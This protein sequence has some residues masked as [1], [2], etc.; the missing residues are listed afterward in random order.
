[1]KNKQLRNRIV[2]LIRELKAI[3]LP[4]YELRR[5]ITGRKHSISGI[6]YS[7]YAE[8]H[9]QMLEWSTENNIPLDEIQ[10]SFE[11]ETDWE[12]WSEPILCVSSTALETDDEY[13]PRLLQLKVDKI[14]SKSITD[15]EWAQIFLSINSTLYMARNIAMSQLKVIECLDDLSKIHNAMYNDHNGQANEYD[16]VLKQVSIYKAMKS[17]YL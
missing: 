9:E 17:K 7:S 8:I 12:G 16:M 4:R 3:G 6:D 5:C 13:H 2:E 14:K 1:M 11:L 15:A 10:I